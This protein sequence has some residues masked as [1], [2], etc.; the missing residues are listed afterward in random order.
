[1]NNKATFVAKFYLKFSQKAEL[2]ANKCFYYSFLDGYSRKKCYLCKQKTH[3]NVPIM[4][5][6]NIYNI[7]KSILDEVEITSTVEA[8]DWVVVA[9]DPANDCSNRYVKFNIQVPDG[10]HQFVIEGNSMSPRGIEHGCNVL[11]SKVSN[12]SNVHD[13]DFVIVDVD[14]EYYKPGDTAHYTHKLRRYI[15]DFKGGIS[16]DSMIEELVNSGNHDEILLESNQVT[17]KKKLNKARSFYGENETLALS[18]TYHNGILQ[19][20]FHKPGNISYKVESLI[21]QDNIDRIYTISQIQD[22]IS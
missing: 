11:C 18:V 10:M 1:M 8:P 17:L 21:Y 16:A 5:L 9:G 13:G 2:C 19:Y 6:S 3:K 22:R 4:R 7:F 20:S 12:E 15:C 14:K